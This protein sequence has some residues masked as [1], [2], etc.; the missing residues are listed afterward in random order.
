M[1]QHLVQD[2]LPVRSQERRPAGQHLVEHCPERVDIGRWADLFN[3]TRGLL[4]GHVGDRSAEPLRLPVFGIE[5]PRESKVGDLGNRRC[6]LL[7]VLLKQHIGR[8]QIAVNEAASVG[9]VDRAGDCLKQPGRRDGRLR[10]AR[11]ELIETAALDEFERDVWAAADLPDIEDLDDVRMLEPRDRF[12]FLTQTGFV[13]R[14]G[15]G[16]VAKDLE[17]DDALEPLVPR[18]IDDAHPAVADEVE[19]LVFRNRGRR[20]VRLFSIRSGLDVIAGLVRIERVIRPGEVDFELLA[21]S[22]GQVGKPRGV[23]IPCW[24]FAG[25]FAQDDLVIDEVEEVFG[26]R[27]QERVA[28]EIGLDRRSPAVR[29]G[30]LLIGHENQNIRLAAHRT[31]PEA[32][33]SRIRS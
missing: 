17:R 15:G 31:S 16:P 12:G 20:L 13:F 19:N 6:L 5:P 1:R 26:P 7:L 11:E 29:P 4:R 32:S 14:T 23:F 18:A 2:D 21:E 30:L 3:P 9:R 27:E 33:D 28:I 8:L 25:S 22:F 24:F 10:R